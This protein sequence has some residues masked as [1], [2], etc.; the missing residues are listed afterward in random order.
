M[1]RAKSG[2]IA[3]G[4]LRCPWSPACR[5]STPAAA[6]RALPDR[7]AP[8]RSRGR[9]PDYGRRRARAR[10]RRARARRA[11]VRQPVQARRPVG[12]GHARIVG[13]RRNCEPTDRAQRRDREACVLE[14]V[15][16]VEL[17]RR[18][19]EQSAFILIYKAAALLGCGPVLAGDFSGA[20]EPRRLPFDHGQRVARLRRRRS[21]ARRA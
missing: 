17:R 11:A 4:S 12:L 9:R 21:P 2:K 1:R 20:R 19:I 6:T 7:R 16:A 18:Q 15:P 3:A 10:C 5:R 8:P 14:L 13:G